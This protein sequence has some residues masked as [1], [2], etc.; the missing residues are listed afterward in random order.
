MS[1]LAQDQYSKE[2]IEEILV[3]L[4]SAV[5]HKNDYQAARQMRIDSLTRVVRSCAPNLYVA[6]CKELYDALYDYDGKQTLKVLERIEKTEE[7]KEDANLRAWV[8][9]NASHVYGIMG[10]YHKANGI[11]DEMNPL[12]LSIEERLHYYN[13]C[14]RNYERISDYMSDI[15]VVQDEEKQMISYFDSILAIQPIGRGRHL[16][17]ANKEIC[18]NHPEKAIWAILPDLPNTQGKER[19][20]ICMTLASAYEKLN[21]K[22][23]YIY[24][25]AITAIED[26]KSGTTEYMALPYLIQ[27][28]YDEGDIDRAY[29]YFMCT[30]EDAN[31]YPSRSLAL[32]VSRYFPLISSSY[33]NHKENIEQSNNMKRN[34]IAVTLV[35]LVISIGV[36]FYLGWHQNNAAEERRRA[37]RLQKALDQ[38]AIADRIKS[39]FIQNM[40]HEI[41]T[42][43]NAI[44]GFAQLMTNDLSDE[45]RSLYSGYIQE[46][47]KQLLTT[48]DSIIDVSNMEV[49]TF[50]FHFESIDLDELCKEQLDEIKDL[51]LQDVK[52]IYQPE[53]SGMRINSD[54]KRIGQVLHNLLSNAC[55]N[56][57]HGTITLSVS[58]HIPSDTI[59]FTVTDTGTGVPPDKVDLI[60]QHFEKLDHYS[61]GLGLGLYVSR[62]IARALGGDISLDTTYTTGARFVFTVPYNNQ[63]EVEKHEEEQ[64]EEAGLISHFQFS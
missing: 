22:Q 45:E 2:E 59:R 42:P 40:R 32:N 56:T 1:L 44:M 13:T 15:D 28:I 21:D 46:S 6:K 64:K 4:D 41:R 3:E 47:N 58:H 30:M 43:L 49:G 24:Y 5:A 29:K 20:N 34:S 11:T 18:L 26:I 37:N 50:D 63:P 14:Q 62:L 38:A 27:A 9:L 61:P 31:F 51:L 35:L 16:T 12:V 19:V 25:L 53:T 17:L 23:I 8:N 52:P 54:K 60:F 10:L 36:A 7:Y 39:V 57:P 48:L 33:S 55:K